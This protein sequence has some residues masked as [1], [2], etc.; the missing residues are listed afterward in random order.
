[1]G[2]ECGLD[3]GDSRDDVVDGLATRQLHTGA[4]F[5]DVHERGHDLRSGQANR[6]GDVWPG[7]ELTFHADLGATPSADPP[8]DAAS[9]GERCAERGHRGRERADGHCCGEPTAERRRDCGQVDA[10]GGSLE[11]RVD[12]LLVLWGLLPAVMAEGAD[13]TVDDTADLRSEAARR[14]VEAERD[15]DQRVPEL[16]AAVAVEHPSRDGEDEDK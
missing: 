4:P 16:Q 13:D 10:L 11:D 2:A 1:M 15:A 6:V 3:R 5:P 8:R 14:Q 7:F 9:H 12:H